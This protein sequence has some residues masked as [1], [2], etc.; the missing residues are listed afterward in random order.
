MHH[1]YQKMSKSKVHIDFAMRY[2][3]KGIGIYELHIFP[4][5]GNFEMRIE[6]NHEI[7]YSDTSQQ[8]F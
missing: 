4:K 6:S 5:L 8:E 3:R 1:F 2:T 7:I